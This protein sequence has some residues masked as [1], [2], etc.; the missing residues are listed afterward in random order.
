MFIKEQIVQNDFST[1]EQDEN[2]SFR[3]SV[4]FFFSKQKTNSNSKTN[5]GKDKQDR[6]QKCNNLS[7]DQHS[8]IDQVQL[9]QHQ[10]HKAQIS[11]HRQTMTPI[12]NNN[13]FHRLEDQVV[14]QQQ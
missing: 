8:E 11:I 5:L 4:L 10:R 7:F 12:T 9:L 2:I 3:I 13:N 14:K 6:T 1:D